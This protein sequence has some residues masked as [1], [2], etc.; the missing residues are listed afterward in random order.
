MKNAP[1]PFLLTLAV[2]WLSLGAVGAQYVLAVRQAQAA[3]LAVTPLDKP[4]GASGPATGD[5]QSGTSAPGPKVLVAGGGPADDPNPPPAPPSRLPDGGAWSSGDKLV[6]LTATLNDQVRD[7]LNVQVANICT[8]H[9]GELVGGDVFV[10]APD[11]LWRWAEWRQV[12]KPESFHALDAA[13]TFGK[14]A[15]DVEAIGK[16]RG[17]KPFRTLV[18]WHSALF[19]QDPVVNLVHIPDA[20]VIW[21]GLDSEQQKMDTSPP[22][23]CCSGCSAGSGCGLTGTWLAA[24][25]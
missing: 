6:L 19:P 20:E 12:E 22:R 15:R 7:E 1:F 16:Q 10:V 18:L 2:A 21:S 11:R 14:V 24:A 23:T 13:E 25:G 8:D 3:Q 9:R 4:P 17:G 5:P